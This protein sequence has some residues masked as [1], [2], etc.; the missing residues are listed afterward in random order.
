MYLIL[1]FQGV[2]YNMDIKNY[3][4]I[5]FVGIGGIS[6]SGLA[7]LLKSKGHEVSGSDIRESA[8][9]DKLK[10][11]GINVHIGHDPSNVKGSDL[12]VYTAAIKQDNPELVSAKELGIPVMDR[13]S[14][15]GQVM[16]R[17]PKTVAVAG[18]HGKTTATSLISVVLMRAGLDPTVLVGGEVD[19]LGGN[20]RVG[21][22]QYMVAESC[23][24]QDS[25]LKFHPFI[26]IVLNMEWDHVDYF[27]NMDSIKKSF[28]NFAKLIP[29]DGCLIV[30]GDNSASSLLPYVD[31]NTLTFGLQ[32]KNDWKADNISYN[33]QGCSSFDVLYK[34]KKMGNIS[35]AIPGEHN[36][37]NALAAAAT[38]YSLGIP[39]DT[40]EEYID[41]FTGTHRRFEIK[42]QANGATVIDDYGHHPSEIKA[43]LKAAK[44][45]PHKKI[46]CVFQPHTYTRTH[47]FLNQ[48]AGAFYDA[49]S[50]IVTDIYAAREKD[51]GLVKSQ[52]LVDKLKSNGVNAV[53]MSEFSKIADYLMDNIE[54][55]DLVITQGAG[56]ITS[57][58]DILLSHS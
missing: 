40:V 8:L 56:T 43:T 22:S 15:M 39:I 9:T 32:S 13:A 36:I 24:Y 29:D 21:S 54:S 38:C 57:L 17:Y 47:A 42:G 10:S 26:G 16:L 7:I 2:V 23:E 45:Y 48:F 44:N 41:E 52:D 25:F 19:I 55:G 30:C 31:C 28:V 51:T 50:V 46:W 33:Q 34:G 5:Y 6:M 37:Y 1:A 53:Y 58:G 35:L 4:N 12:V 49:D 14:L 27:K 3:R 18:S 11:H 20:V